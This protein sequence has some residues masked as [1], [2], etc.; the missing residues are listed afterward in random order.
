MGMRRTNLDLCGIVGLGYENMI[1]PMSLRQTPPDAA[2]VKPEDAHSNQGFV[3][4][5]LG[6]RTLSPIVSR[7][8]P[9][10]T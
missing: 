10:V 4:V 9:Y 8:L 3:E 5:W 2:S 1:G 6:A 7:W